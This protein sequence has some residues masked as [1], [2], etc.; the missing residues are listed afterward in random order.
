[1]NG[2]LGSLFFALSK[3]QIPCEVFHFVEIK[4]KKHKIV[5]GNIK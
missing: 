5:G 2:A 4:K 1:M 3:C